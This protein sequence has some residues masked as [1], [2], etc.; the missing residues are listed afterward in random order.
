MGVPVNCEEPHRV[1]MTESM[2]A[3]A[4]V[5]FPQFRFQTTTTPDLHEADPALS[6]QLALMKTAL[7]TQTYADLVGHRK[8]TAGDVLCDL[9]A[10][11][12]DGQITGPSL[13]AL[14][15]PCPGSSPANG[16][17]APPVFPLPKLPQGTDKEEDKKLGPFSIKC[18]TEERQKK[19]R[20]YKEKLRRRR[21]VHPVSRRY[22]GRS[23]VAYL[24]VRNNG[25][26]KTN[27]R[28]ST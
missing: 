18:T 4:M 1:L 11:C 20:K 12:E 15:T 9:F 14:E 3:D 19:I 26:F 8:L 2:R 22:P 21:L 23:Q 13:P 17:V 27:N 6:A 5:L 25:K 24:K 7:L 10:G 16:L 28:L